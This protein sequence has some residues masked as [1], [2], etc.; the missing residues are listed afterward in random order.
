MSIWL[1]YSSFLFRIH[2]QCF[3]LSFIEYQCEITTDVCTYEFRFQWQFHAS[4]GKSHDVRTSCLRKPFMRISHEPTY[5]LKLIAVQNEWNLL[6]WICSIFFNANSS[7]RLVWAI[8]LYMVNK[9]HSYRL[10]INHSRRSRESCFFD[11]ALI[12]MI[13]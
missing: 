8:Y 12:S 10:P 13:H 5:I 3:F 9:V 4:S 2:L 6:F 1:I 11:A 7:F